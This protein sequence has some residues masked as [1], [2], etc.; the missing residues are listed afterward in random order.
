MILKFDKRYVQ[1]LV[2]MVCVSLASCNQDVRPR[3]LDGKWELKR[4]DGV[5]VDPGSIWEFE[6]NGDFEFCQD[7]DCY[8]GDW[9]WEDRGEEL[10]I[11]YT[12]DFGDSYRINFEVDMLDKEVLEG[13]LSLDAYTFTAEFERD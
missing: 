8:S 5:N 11:N 13:D 3:Q 9:E 7:G 10:E 4:V 2:V 6:K 1:A 12:D